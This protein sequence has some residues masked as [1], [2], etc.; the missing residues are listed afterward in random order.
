MT[1]ELEERI[2]TLEAELA[3]ARAAVF[4]PSGPDVVSV[5]PEVKPLFDQAA[6]TIRGYFDKIEIDP[7]RALIG[8]GDERYLLVRASAFSIDFLDT[9]VHLYKDRGPRDA[10]AIGRGFLFDIAHTIGYHDARAL[11]EK[12]GSR[13]PLEKLSGGPVHFA[14]T[15]WA[16]VDIKPESKPVPNEDFCLVYE[17][18]YSFE[19][20]SYL[21]AGRASEGPVCIMN[22]GYSSGW[23][24]A[25]FDI[26]L[27]AVE[28]SCKARGDAAC[29][30]VMAPPQHMAARAREHC[31][32][33]LGA[34]GE[35]SFDIPQYFEHKRAALL[36]EHNINSNKP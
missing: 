19:A 17:H 24:E 1:K 27:T 8:V 13:D 32:L 26:E 9:L 23:C 6:Q 7:A 30:F 14:Y 36:V 34:L 4:A 18:P 2:R 33:D 16:F 5:P 20:A 3:R 12:L 31:G 35:K 25:S 10:L 28:V 22:A 21:R 29:R 11:H 15:G